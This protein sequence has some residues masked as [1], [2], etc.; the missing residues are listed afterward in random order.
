MGCSPRGREDSDTPERLPFPLAHKVSAEKPV[1]SLTGA[2]FYKKRFSPPD[3]LKP[4][5]LLLDSSITLRLEDHRG[6]KF[7]GEVY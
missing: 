4:L 7:W 1:A 3:A 2:S 5:S 6:L